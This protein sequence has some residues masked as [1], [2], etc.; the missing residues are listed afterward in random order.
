WVVS[1]TGIGAHLSE[2]DRKKAIDKVHAH[3]G[4]INTAYNSLVNAVSEVGVAITTA[5]QEI[6]VRGDQL[7]DG[8]DAPAAAP[9]NSGV[10]GGEDG[11]AVRE[12]I[13][14]DGTVDPAVLDQIASRLPQQALTQSELDTLAAGGEVSTLPASVQDYYREFYQN[15]G[16][17]GILA[18]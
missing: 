13:R 16:K 1:C 15:A 5:T 14:P 12:A 18:M 8:S 2:D 6:R 11:K 7:G 3:Q 4:L 17:D 10:L 9:A